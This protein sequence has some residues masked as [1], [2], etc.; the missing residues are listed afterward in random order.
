MFL[1]ISGTRRRFRCWLD[2]FGL[3]ADGGCGGRGGKVAFTKLFDV[4]SDSL[5]FGY[6]QLMTH[7]IH[8]LDKYIHKPRTP[9]RNHE[10]VCTRMY[11]SESRATPHVSL[12]WVHNG[13]RIDGK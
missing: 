10:P 7:H 2:T 1:C 12:N 9:A 8:S 6:V 3:I 5:E 4:S 13:H 11:V